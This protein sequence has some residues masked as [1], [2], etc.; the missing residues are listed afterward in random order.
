[1][2]AIHQAHV[3]GGNDDCLTTL[4]LGLVPRRP[5]RP[6]LRRQHETATA[7]ANATRAALTRKRFL[8]PVNWMDMT[9]HSFRRAGRSPAPS[10]ASDSGCCGMGAIR[11]RNACD[12][13]DPSGAA[14][15]VVRP[16]GQELLPLTTGKLRP[17]TAHARSSQSDGSTS[18]T[19]PWP[20]SE[21]TTTLRPSG[22]NAAAANRPA[23]GPGNRSPMM[24]RVATS[25]RST[26]PAA[27]APTTVAPSGDRSTVSTFPVRPSAALPASGSA[28]P[29]GARCWFGHRSRACGH[30]S[31]CRPPTHPRRRLARSP[32]CA[33]RPCPRGRS[34]RRRPI[35]SRPRAANRPA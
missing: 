8:A 18:H 3:G 27:S 2:A 6:R 34:T 23:V 9:I 12:S 31:R 14:G 35:P 22:V 21:M 15:G 10:S 24:D 13:E 20:V 19:H 17:A 16:V 25:Q 28:G 26:L 4:D 5:D 32:G 33:V 11:L 30:R 7:R 1:M 29:R